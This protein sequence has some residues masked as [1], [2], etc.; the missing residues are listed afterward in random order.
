MNITS[1]TDSPSGGTSINRLTIVSVNMHGMKMA[2]VFMKCL[3]IPWK[4]FGHYYVLGSGR[5]EGFHKKNGPCLLAFSNMCIMSVNAVNRCS[6]RLFSD[7][8]VKTLESIL[9]LFFND[10]Y[11]EKNSIKLFLNVL[12]SSCGKFT[13]SFMECLD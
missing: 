13:R 2:M 10:L 4:A 9:S 11:C 8:S 7:W 6:I 3:S 1:I 12:L 5:I